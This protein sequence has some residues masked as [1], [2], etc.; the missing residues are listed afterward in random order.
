[1][2]V[3]IIENWSYFSNG[4]GR[5]LDRSFLRAFLLKF[6]QA[7][8]IQELREIGRCAHVC[9]RQIHIHSYT[10]T[11]T[12]GFRIYLLACGKTCRRVGKREKGRYSIR[13]ITFLNRKGDYAGYAGGH[14]KRCLCFVS[15]YNV[16]AAIFTMRTNS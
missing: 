6:R 14:Y 4:G 7:G 1:M 15:K 13:E 2:T 8:V 9:T 5:L 3:V 11:S 12:N 10:S 16:P